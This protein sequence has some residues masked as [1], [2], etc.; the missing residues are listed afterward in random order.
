MFIICMGVGKICDVLLLLLEVVW[1]FGV[2]L[3]WVI[4]LMYGNGIIMLIGYKICCFD[5]V[6]DEVCG[7]FEVY[8]VVGM[9]L[10]GIYVEFIG[11]DVIECFGGF[12]Q[13]DEVV[14]VICYESLCDLCLNYMQLFELVFFVV[15]EF[16]KC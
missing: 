5:D 16:E 7:F 12:E 10:G 15:E 4:D 11:D 8:C 14:F 9:F 2:Q 3:L 6:V 1:E 13:I